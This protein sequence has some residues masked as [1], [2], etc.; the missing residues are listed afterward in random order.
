MGSNG[1]KEFAEKSIDGLRR[2]FFKK[3]AIIR[4]PWIDHYLCILENSTLCYKGEERASF[5]S[6]ENGR[7]PEK[8]TILFFRPIIVNIIIVKKLWLG[9]KL[10]QW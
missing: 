5:L 4:F 1:N 3:D 9:K 2:N 8:H 6:S 10:V 7:S